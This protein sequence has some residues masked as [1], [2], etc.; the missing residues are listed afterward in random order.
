MLNAVVPVW[1]T[2]IAE[3][4]SRGTFVAKEFTLNIAGVAAAYWVGYGYH[5]TS[6]SSWRFPIAWQL[7]PLV[8]LLAFIWFFPESPRWLAKVSKMDESK[9]IL[10]RLRGDD[11][12]HP[13]KAEREF[14]GICKEVTLEKDEHT[15]PQSYWKMFFGV[16][17][18]N[19]HLGRRIQL[20]IW[21]QVM[22]EMLG[23][24]GGSSLPTENCFRL[25]SNLHRCHCLWNNH[26][27]RCWYRL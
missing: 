26:L 12:S 18:G 17:S 22:Q 3:H 7:L 25:S 4:T 10:V 27:S 8:L 11:N 14:Q 5:G 20:V 19:Y 15:L 23:I 9:F 1:S 24:A 2:E 13:G 21:L 6:A 16:E